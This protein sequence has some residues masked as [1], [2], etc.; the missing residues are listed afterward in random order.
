MSVITWGCGPKNLQY[1]YVLYCKRVHPHVITPAGAAYRNDLFFTKDAPWI[2]TLY[3]D[4]LF[5]VWCAQEHAQQQADYE[6]PPEHDALAETL[7]RR[8]VEEVVRELQQHGLPAAAAQEV[9]AVRVQCSFARVRC[10]RLLLFVPR[11]CVCGVCLR[12]LARP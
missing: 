5:P 10:E 9:G 1:T 2:L 8:Q 4:T 6:Q 11:V 3:Y 12:L 7:A